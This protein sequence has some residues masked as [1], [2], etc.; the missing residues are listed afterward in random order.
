M[1]VKKESLT[2]LKKDYDNIEFANAVIHETRL[3]SQTD[4]HI[5][6]LGL[7]I[8]LDRSGSG[9]ASQCC[10]MTIHSDIVKHICGFLDAIDVTSWEELKGKPVQIIMQNGRAVGLCHFVNEYSYHL[11]EELCPL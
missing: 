8:Y 11:L 6:N 1:L 2:D 9:H 7:Y 10:S 4:A 3:G 5:Y